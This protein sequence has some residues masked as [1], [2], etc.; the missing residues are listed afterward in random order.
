MTSGSNPADPYFYPYRYGTAVTGKFMVVKYRLSN[1]GQNMTVNAPYASSAA[2]GQSGA[3][4][5][6]GDGSNNITPTTLYSDGE[7]HYFIVTPKDDNTTFTPNA[8]GTYSW[9]YFRVRLNGFA[10]YDEIA[11]ADC[12]EAADAYIVK[13]NPVQNLDKSGL[14]LTSVWTTGAALSR[15]TDGNLVVSN[16]ADGTGKNDAGN[17]KDN[18]VSF[19]NT[20][21]F[22]TYSGRY[23]VIIAKA[24]NEHSMINNIYMQDDVAKSYQNFGSF[25]I[26]E[27]VGEW[28]A[29]IVDSSTMLTE[30]SNIYV[31]RVDCCEASDTVGD[32]SVTFKSA[33]TYDTLEEAEAAAKAAGVTKVFTK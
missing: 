3:A 16:G 21:D 9:G 8:D 10:A 27:N 14:G 5:K 19:V 25:A 29:I 17:Y 24:H 30:G 1:K 4:G 20:T 33:A 12:R 7:W 22:K 18:Y 32:R 11:F 23:V 28:V 13:N 15:D 6:N 2:N 31:L 26:N